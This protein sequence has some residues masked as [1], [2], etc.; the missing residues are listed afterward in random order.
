M[1]TYIKGQQQKSGRQKE[2]RLPIPQEGIDI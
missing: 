2:T 1:A